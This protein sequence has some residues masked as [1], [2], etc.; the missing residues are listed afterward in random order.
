MK[1]IVHQQKCR[2]ATLHSEEVLWIPKPK[3]PA[4]DWAWACTTNTCA[5]FLVLKDGRWV[6]VNCNSINFDSFTWMV[7][8][9]LPW[10]VLWMTTS[11]PGTMCLLGVPVPKFEECETC[12]GWVHWIW[13]D[14][15]YSQWWGLLARP[16]PWLDFFPLEVLSM[17]SGWNENT[18][19]IRTIVHETWM[20][21]AKHTGEI[22][23][24]G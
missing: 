13:L 24:W 9:G 17:D 11:K 18:W 8:M 2:A 4:A 14:H 23:P 3:R 16:N 6:P 7:W 21:G 1:G 22:W 5:D 19:T 20:H 12:L 10:M 15:C